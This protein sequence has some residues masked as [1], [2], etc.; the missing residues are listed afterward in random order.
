MAEHLLR[1]EGDERAARFVY[2][3][4]PA[5]ASRGR[6]S[7]D[8]VKSV[9]RHLNDFLENPLL[10]FLETNPMTSIGT[11]RMR[12]REGLTLCGLGR[13]GR[14]L[15]PRGCCCKF[16]PPPSH[17]QLYIWPR[18]AGRNRAPD[19]VWE[20]RSSLFGG[21]GGGR[22]GGQPRPRCHQSQPRPGNGA[23]KRSSPPSLVMSSKDISRA[24]YFAKLP[25]KI[26][27]N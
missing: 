25:Q 21:R 5:D 15:G 24:I 23:D 20:V 14:V 8:T 26:L 7:S 6:S 19:G 3:P 16:R 10:D 17:R 1:G 2:P 22:W 12:V 13:R 18:Q 9:Q 27:H 11:R 4:S